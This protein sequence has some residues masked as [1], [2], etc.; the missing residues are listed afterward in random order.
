Y[1]TTQ[2]LSQTR[3]NRPGIFPMGV[4]SGVWNDMANS[5]QF[6]GQGRELLVTFAIEII[7]REISR[8]EGGTQVWLHGERGCLK[9]HRQV[10]AR[11]ATAQ[12][13]E[14]PALAVRQGGKDRLL[15]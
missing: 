10:C 4:V 8:A 1:S 5:V 15:I 14:R 9:H 12:G 11:V 6:S 2:Y 3:A 7:K 13:D